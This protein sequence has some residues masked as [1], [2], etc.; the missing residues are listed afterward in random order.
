[1]QQGVDKNPPHDNSCPGLYADPTSKIA[2]WQNNPNKFINIGQVIMKGSKGYA[3][4][5]ENKN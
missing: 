3:I 2:Y 5:Q 1:M 4:F